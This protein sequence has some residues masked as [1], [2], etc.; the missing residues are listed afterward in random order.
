M[1]LSK[2]YRYLLEIVPGVANIPKLVLDLLSF[3]LIAAETSVSVMMTT[4][5]PLLLIFYQSKQ[6]HDTL[7]HE[8]LFQPN[9]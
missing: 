6:T 5:L 3:V 9:Y 1:S 4:P 8:S 2:L 7:L